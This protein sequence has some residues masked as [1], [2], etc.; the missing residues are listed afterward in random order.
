MRRAD[1]DGGLG[2]RLE[3]GDWRSVIGDWRLDIGNWGLKFQ[4]SKIKSRRADPKVSDI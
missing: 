3:I 2:M 1:L 4:T